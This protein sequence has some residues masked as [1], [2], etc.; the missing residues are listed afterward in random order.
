MWKREEEREK[1]SALMQASWAWKYRHL[2]TQTKM[3]VRR[4]KK[5]KVKYVTT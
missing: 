1:S 5:E 3:H 4:N 2:W